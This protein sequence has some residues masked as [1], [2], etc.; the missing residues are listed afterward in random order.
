MKTKRIKL[1][2]QSANPEE[3]RYAK[4]INKDKENAKIQ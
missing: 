2:S 1:W 4:Q 3:D